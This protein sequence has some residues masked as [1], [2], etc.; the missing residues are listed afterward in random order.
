LEPIENGLKISMPTNSD[1]SLEES[2]TRERL[3]AEAER[4]FAANGYDGTS[5]RRLTEAAGANVAAVSYYFGGK[6]GLYQAVFER[7]LEE[8][9]ER[10]IR[11]IETDLAAAGEAVTLDGFLLSFANAFVEPLVEGERGRDFISLFDQ[12]MRLQKMPTE[13]FFQQLFEPMLALFAASLERAGVAIDRPAAAMCL[14]SLVGQLAHA[15]KAS[16]RFAEGVG[17]EPLPLALA[18]MIPH[19]VRFSAAGIHACAAADGNSG[20]T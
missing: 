20:R 5:V 8:M 18:D 6:E 3:L 15:L 12:E 1:G 7:V 10:R 4:M 11:R 13:A 14:M 2:R 19:I 17:P 16:R 9:R